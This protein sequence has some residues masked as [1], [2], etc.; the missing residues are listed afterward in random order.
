[1]NNKI[2]T[3]DN[4]YNGKI[5]AISP[6]HLGSVALAKN[7]ITSGIKWGTDYVAYAAELEETD[8]PKGFTT[9][10]AKDNDAI[11]ARYVVA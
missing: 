1:M 4:K 11:L 8:S 2:K 10:V 5:V 6:I 3:H 7:G 9:L